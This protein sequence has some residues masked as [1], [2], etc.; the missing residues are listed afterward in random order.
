[1][2]CQRRAVVSHSV[3]EGVGQKMSQKCNNLHIQ[4]TCCPTNKADPS[5]HGRVG[6]AAHHESKLF[7]VCCR[8]AAGGLGVGESPDRWA[9][10][11]HT[12]ESRVSRCSLPMVA[13]F[14]TSVLFTSG[15]PGHSLSVIR[16]LVEAQRG[17][18]TS[19]SRWTRHSLLLANW[20]LRS[21][22]SSNG[23]SHPAGGVSQMTK[24]K[25]HSIRSNLFLAITLGA[26]LT[27]FLWHA[28]GSKRPTLWASEAPSVHPATTRPIAA[29]RKREHVATENSKVTKAKNIHKHREVERHNYD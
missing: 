15:S 17:A 4:V 14:I 22:S 20:I 9:G 25:D 18:R 11:S 24:A 3:S 16:G 5:L 1:M 6:I 28:T 21:D 10:M 23:F 27:M 8:R 26:V 7:R 12:S 19:I 2:K 13:V 29:P